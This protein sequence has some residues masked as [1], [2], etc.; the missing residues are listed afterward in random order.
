MVGLGVPGFYTRHSCF[1]LPPLGPLSNRGDFGAIK[2]RL[3]VFS[4]TFASGGKNVMPHAFCLTFHPKKPDQKKNT[5]IYTYIYIYI[6]LI[7]FA[8]RFQKS[9]ENSFSWEISSNLNDLI[10]R[11]FL[12]AQNPFQNSRKFNP[13]NKHQKSGT[14]SLTL[15]YIYINTWNPTDLCF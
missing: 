15:L 9:S 11:L 8:S 4:K 7:Y 3:P 2:L 10:R 6:Y 12:A 1:F 14:C 5:I 13:R